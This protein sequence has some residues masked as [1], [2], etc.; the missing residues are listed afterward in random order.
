MLTTHIITDRSEIERYT[1]RCQELARESG[2]HLPFQNLHMPL[3][4][5]GHFNNTDGSNFTSKRGTNFLGSQSWLQKLF[6]IVSL[7]G[8][9]VVGAVPVV[10]YAVRIPREQ[11]TLQVITFPGDFL[12]AY[13]DFTVSSQLRKEAIKAL[14]HAMVGFLDGHALLILPYVPENSP[15]IHDLKQCIAE[16]SKMGFHCS[17]ALTGRRGGVREW[18]LESIVSCLGQI[19][20]RVKDSSRLDEI[21][22]LVADLETSPLMNLLFPRTRNSFESRIREVVTMIQGDTA[23]EKPLEK[24]ETLLTDVPVQYPYITLPVDADAYMI[25]MSKETR[26]YFRRYKRDYEGQGGGFEKILSSDIREQD[27]E[28]YLKLHNQRWGDH[29]ILI[30]ND[31]SNDFHKDICWRMSSQGCFTLFF[32]KYHGK[33]VATH[34]CIDIQG[35]REGYMTG[36]DPLYAETRASR[37]LYLETI[38]DA[39]RHGFHTYDLGHGWH[40]YKMSFTKTDIRTMNFFISPGTA[41]V[42]LTKLFLGYEC[43]IP[44]DVHSVSN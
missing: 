26:R 38:I 17:T 39:I 15:N 32:A 36:R 33:R 37:L 9:E 24:L 43:M 14:L 44:M 35:R 42:D 4:W 12:I 19:A 27:I 16:L 40:A 25:T 6:L 30:R 1:P 8:S 2:T 20:D 23:I 28:D 29:S 41:P 18:T 31:T 22:K 21:R 3:V 7:D 5:W 13:Q 34:S 11:D 10:E